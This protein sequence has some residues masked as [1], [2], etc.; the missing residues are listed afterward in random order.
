MTSD[1]SRSLARRIS[2][3]ALTLALVATGLVIGPAAS[4]LASVN[5]DA[6]GDLQAKI[7]AAVSPATILISGTCRGYFDTTGK[8]I[9]LK[10]NPT[11][12]LDG[13]DSYTVVINF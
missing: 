4:A 8:E 10:G 11:A 12:T 6:G 7:D 13:M 1:R 5:C 3:G 2:L 9:T